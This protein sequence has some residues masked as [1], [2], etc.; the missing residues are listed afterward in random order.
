MSNSLC[1]LAMHN[2]LNISKMQIK[3]IALQYKCKANIFLFICF[4]NMIL[5]I[6]LDYWEIFYT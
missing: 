2:I 6:Q 5:N 1:E 4:T 3:K